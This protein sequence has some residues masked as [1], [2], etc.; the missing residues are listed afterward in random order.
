MINF[1]ELNDFMTYD[2]RSRTIAFDD[3]DGQSSHH[4]GEQNIMIQVTLVNTE[5][6]Y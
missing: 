4:A 5:S 2:K 3:N 1:N 6:R